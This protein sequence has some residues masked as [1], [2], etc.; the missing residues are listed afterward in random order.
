M[1]GGIISRA[2]YLGTRP[3]DIQGFHAG[4]RGVGAGRGKARPMGRWQ[5]LL[6]PGDMSQRFGFFRRE[7]A[8]AHN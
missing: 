1:S 5:V 7:Y 6:V 8:S 3:G 4:W 2:E